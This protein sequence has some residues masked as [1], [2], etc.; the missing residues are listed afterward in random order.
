MLKLQEKLVSSPK[1]SVRKNGGLCI[2]KTDVCGENNGRM[3]LHMKNKHVDGA[4]TY[5]FTT[6]DD[7]ERSSHRTYDEFLAVVL[8]IFSYVHNRMVPRLRS[9]PMNMLSIESPT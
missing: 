8:A 3:S 5:R 2:L 7:R 6:L 9:E 1:V 4:M